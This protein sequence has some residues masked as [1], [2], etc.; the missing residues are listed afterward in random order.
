MSDELQLYAMTCG[1]LSLP[2]VAL[3]EGGASEDLRIP[4]PCYLI[5]H[6]RGTALFDS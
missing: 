6:Q 1:W 5:V 3:I 4:V 2:E